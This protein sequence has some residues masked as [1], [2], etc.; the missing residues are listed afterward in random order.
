MDTGP[1]R[2][3]EH[4]LSSRLILGTGKYADLEVMR[5]AFEVAGTEMVTVAIRRVD[6]DSGEPTIL[7]FIDTERITVL[8]NTA[9][10]YSAEDAVRTARLARELGFKDLVKLEVLSDEKTLL[11]DPVATL[12]A[13]RTLVSE[14]FTVLAYTSDDPAVAKQIEA[15]G[16]TS[17]MPLGSPIG[18]VQRILNPQNISSIFE[19][20]EVPI[21][22]DAGVGTAS[23]VSIAMELGA[24]GVLL[25]TG[26]AQAK[27]PVRMARAMSLACEAGRLAFLAGRIPKRRY[28]QASSPV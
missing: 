28:A 3:G 6:F 2:V 16:A 10:C 19:L 26:A 9:G 8:P 1:L 18:S 14:G 7:D 21:I 23:D 5:K 24:D 15:A 13:T 25:N 20:A 11:P 27:D 17:V 22:V 12:E 4:E